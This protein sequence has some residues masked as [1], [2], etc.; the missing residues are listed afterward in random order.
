M[1]ST[2]N[3]SS[4]RALLVLAFG[5]LCISFA[6][7]FVKVLGRDVLGPT[8]IGFWRTIFGAA[9][10]FGW[11]IV[12]GGSLKM[13]ASIVGFSLVAG[14]VFFLDLFFWHRSIV[15]AGAGMA[16]ILANTQVFFVSVVG[17]LLFKERLSLLFVV[18]VVAAFGGVVLLIGVGSDVE[19]ST[20][21]VNGVVF[22]LLTGI[23]YGTYLLTLKKAGHRP[24]CPSMLTVI[25]WT[26]LFTAFFCGV[27]MLIESDPYIPP[28]LY[29]VLILFALALV[30]QAVGW[31]VISRTLPKLRASQSALIL[32]LQPVLATVWGVIFF[33]EHLT[34]LQIVGAAI[35]LM[36]IYAG[37][38]RRNQ[39]GY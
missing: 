19:F 28:D 37:S 29:S 27:S 21:Y 20:V 15:F 7:I 25:A 9:I 14:F 34:L 24:D 30:A 8:A 1:N 31:Y 2:D 38:V 23:V 10:L 26:S 36:A 33:A 18:A 5:A 17:Y 13:P 12:K 16:T 4:L 32:L 39:A 3:N 35:T 6:A 22:G 11:V